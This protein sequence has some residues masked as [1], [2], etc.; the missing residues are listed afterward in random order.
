MTQ[1]PDPKPKRRDAVPLW[2]MGFIVL[3]VIFIAA[4]GTQ[5]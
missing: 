5:S 3:M 4:Y 2:I 1:P